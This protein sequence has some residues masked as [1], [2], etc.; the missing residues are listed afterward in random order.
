MSHLTKYP[1]MLFPLAGDV[2]KAQRRPGHAHLL[3]NQDYEGISVLDVW[4]QR[5][6]STIPFPP[7]FAAARIIDN[8]C[9]RADGNAVMLLNEEER[10]ASFLS[11]TQN[12][13]AYDLEIPSAIRDVQDLRYLW[14]EDA[15]WLAGGRTVSIFT[16]QE[17]K[18]TPVLVE[19]SNLQARI[20]QTG[21]VRALDL[22]PTYRCNVLSVQSDTGEIRY[23]TFAD[24]PVVGVLN[25][26]DSFRLSVPAPEEVPN[27]A[28]GAGRLFILQEYE[29]HELN[30]QGEIQAVYPVTDGFHY[31]CFDTL[32]ANQGR[33]PALVAIAS[34]LSDDR[35]SQVQVYHLDNLSSS[36]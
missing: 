12:E 20:A 27:L 13:P 6:I 36:S 17:Q 33:P 24:R 9:L 30:E 5:I 16:L 11:L 2:Y 21:W 31:Y 1:D 35:A 10:F 8:W 7:R 15:F 4:Q 28:F 25:W 29:I 3:V 26:K 19:K 34:K 18:N 23:H 14:Q 32:R 22:L